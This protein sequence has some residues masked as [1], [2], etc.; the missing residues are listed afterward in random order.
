MSQYMFVGQQFAGLGS[1]FLP[2][3]SRRSDSGCHP[4]TSPRPVDLEIPHRSLIYVQCCVSQEY[5]MK[6]LNVYAPTLKMTHRCWGDDGQEV[7]CAGMKE[8]LCP[9]PSHQVKQRGSSNLLPQLLQR[10]GGLKSRRVSVPS[11]VLTGG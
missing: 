4:V 11:P 1:F 6:I 10:D 3:V 9:S 8:E 5:G 2:R 7:L